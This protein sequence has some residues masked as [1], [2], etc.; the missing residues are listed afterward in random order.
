MTEDYFSENT[1]T[2]IPDYGEISGQERAKRGIEVA[3]AG[4]HNIMMIGPPGAGKTMIAQRIPGILPPLDLKESLEVSAI[5][6]VAGLLKENEALI[7]HRPFLNPHHTI[8]EPAL[9]GGGR[10]PRPGVISLAHHAVLF[11]DEFGEFKRKTLDKMKKESSHWARRG[12]QRKRRVLRTGK[13]RPASWVSLHKCLSGCT[14]RVT[15]S[16]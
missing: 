3:A 9:I 1:K 10:I 4:F 15:V 2:N 12:R 8:S 11:L 16:A 6:S 14:I 7:T 13:R 5:Y